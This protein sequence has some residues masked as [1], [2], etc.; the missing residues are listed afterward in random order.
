[1]CS[2]FTKGL[3]LV[4]EARI[5]LAAPCFQSTVVT[6]TYSTMVGVEGVEPSDYGF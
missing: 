2:H 4:A 3:K 1:M 5:E 6:L